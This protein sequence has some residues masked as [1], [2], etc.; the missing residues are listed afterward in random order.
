L[1]AAKRQ[2]AKCRRREGEQAGTREHGTH[3]GKAEQRPGAFSGD[4]VVRGE[5]GDQTDQESRSA[6]HEPQLA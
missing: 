2:R 1:T 6:G 3:A 5:T 4:A